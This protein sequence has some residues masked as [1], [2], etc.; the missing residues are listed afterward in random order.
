LQAGELEQRD[1]MCWQLLR[2]LAALDASGEAAVK[3]L[4]SV[5]VKEEAGVA[6]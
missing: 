1:D 5:V 4:L 2:Q 3:Q 6:Q